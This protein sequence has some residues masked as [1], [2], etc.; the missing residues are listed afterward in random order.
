MGPRLPDAVEWLQ[1]S[2]IRI[3]FA[4]VKSGWNATL[5]IGIN[6]QW[7]EVEREE[8]A[9]PPR[10]YVYVLRPAPTGKILRAYQE[11]DVAPPDAPEI[12]TP[13]RI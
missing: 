3:A 5:T 8:Q 11:Y 9:Q 13:G 1:D 2:R 12:K 4:A 7:F 6:G 10:P